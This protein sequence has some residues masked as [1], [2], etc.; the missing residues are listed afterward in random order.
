VG[1][2]IGRARKAGMRRREVRAVRHLRAAQ[3]CFR[4][5]VRSAIDGLPV[6][7]RAARGSG[8]RADVVR[9]GVVKIVVVQDIDVRDPR[10][11]DVH[12]ADI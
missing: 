2:C 9:V 5:P 8:H 10:V 1:P 12:V 4:H 11:V 7:K 6:H 3:R